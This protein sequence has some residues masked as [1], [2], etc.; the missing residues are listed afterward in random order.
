[1]LQALSTYKL[2]DEQ[3]ADPEL[4]VLTGVLPAQPAGLLISSSC[5]CAQTGCLAL[6]GAPVMAAGFLASFS[7]S[8][9]PAGLTALLCICSSRYVLA[10]ASGRLID[11]A[12]WHRHAELH[13]QD[14]AVHCQRHAAPHN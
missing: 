10:S 11:W 4:D 8:C 3:A 13:L 5:K 1:M 2:S 14:V 9:A 7:Y 6:D 12:T